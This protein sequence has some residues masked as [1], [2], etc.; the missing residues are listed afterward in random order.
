[1]V[2]IS[3]PGVDAATNS[4]ASAILNARAKPTHWTAKL[5]FLAEPVQAQEV[6]DRACVR[7]DLLDVATILVYIDRAYFDDPGS[8]W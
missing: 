3:E 6:R 8:M 7:V 1:M 5:C 4:E 2:L